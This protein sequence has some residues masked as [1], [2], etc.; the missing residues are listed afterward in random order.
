MFIAPL[1]LATKVIPVEKVNQS[2][3]F[4]DDMRLRKIT[5]A[6]DRQLVYF[7]RADLSTE[8]MFA[9]TKLKRS[10][11]KKSL[12]RFKEITLTT[13]ECFKVEK[14]DICF[15]AMSDTLNNEFDI[16]K[17]I[18]D[19]NERGYATK[20]TLFT[21]YYSPD[22]KGSLV[23][24]GV[25]KNP[26]YKRPSQ[27]SLARLTSDQINY[28]D[29]LEG[30]DLELFYVKESLYDI[31][32]LHVEGGGRV[33]VRQK[34]GSYKKFY[35]S[36]D[37]TNKRSFRMLFKYMLE[38]GML[39]A[40][41]TSIE[42]Q[43]SYFLNNPDKQREI[44]ASCPSY[45]WFKITEDEPLGVKN[46]PLTEGRSLATDYRRMQEYGVINFVKYKKENEENP[47]RNREVSRFFLNQDTGGAIKGNARSDL[48]FGYGK[49]AEKAANFIYGLGDQYFL[50]LKKGK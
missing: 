10:D 12:I 21:A 32:L 7:N 13:I 17:P 29:A 50:V 40:D 9:Q 6:I 24:T 2:I 23:K 44:L 11:L 26:I 46:I 18:P 34:D 8:F 4:S 49:K 45:I 3:N 43:R 16:F 15:K 33:K 47:E 20:Q 31:W 35:L 27:E 1:A 41:A 22:L 19:R 42:N 5:K 28:T 48:Y 36:Y 30:K 39:S 25:Y 38:Q 37:S 14:R